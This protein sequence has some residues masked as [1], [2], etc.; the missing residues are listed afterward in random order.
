[1]TEKKSSQINNYYYS[2][3]GFAHELSQSKGTRIWK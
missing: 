2:S 3:W 1:L